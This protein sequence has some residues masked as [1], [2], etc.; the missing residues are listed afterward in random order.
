MITGT[1]T[2]DNGENKGLFIR[3]AKAGRFQREWKAVL[4]SAPGE[5]NLIRS[6]RLIWAQY[7]YNLA[8]KEYY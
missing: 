4:K 7:L 3:A 8:A 1:G 2:P 6:G 5:K